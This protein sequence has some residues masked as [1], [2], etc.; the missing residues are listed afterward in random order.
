MARIGMELIRTWRKII[1]CQWY[2]KRPDCKPICL[3]VNSWGKAK[4]KS[5]FEGEQ[6]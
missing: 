5:D 3:Y 6:K 2:Q 4:R 1:L